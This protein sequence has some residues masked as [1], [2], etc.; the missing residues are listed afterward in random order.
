M[1]FS[2][3][4]WNLQNSSKHSIRKVLKSLVDREQHAVAMAIFMAFF[5]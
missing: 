3:C 1:C 5:D 4:H 2:A